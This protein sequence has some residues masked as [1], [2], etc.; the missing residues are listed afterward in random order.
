VFNVPHGESF[1]YKILPAAETAKPKRKPVAKPAAKT[2]EV[3]AVKELG[4]PVRKWIKDR[5]EELSEADAIS[6]GEVRKLL[7]AEY[8]LATFGVR[9]P[10]LREIETRS[11]LTE[12]RTA[13][14]KIKY[15]KESFRFNGKTYLV[16]KEWVAGLHRERFA[17][18]LETIKK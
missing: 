2:V 8:A 12:Q 11:N 13:N 6:P 14:G 17:A 18:W 5:V 7:T 15:W 9:N 3:P 16:Y 10:I 1:I 4:V